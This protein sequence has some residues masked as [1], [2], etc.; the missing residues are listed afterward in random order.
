M[1]PHTSRATLPRARLLGILLM[2]VGAGLANGLLGAGGGI[3]VVYA[4]AA[5]LREGHHDPRDLY[6][7][8]LCI[9]LPVSAFSALRYAAAG[10]L[11][12]EDF[13]PYVLPAIAGGLV[14]GLLLEKL[15]G[16]AVKKL[17]AALVIY[18]GLFLM[19]R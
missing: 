8:A 9:M 7:N 3:L 10:N 15:R 18:S 11:P 2:G 14:G 17:F 6:A 19:I 1:K 16:S 13:F 12:T 5:A 4:L